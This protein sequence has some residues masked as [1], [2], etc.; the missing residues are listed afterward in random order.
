MLFLARRTVTLCLLRLLTI[1]AK[2]Q[3]VL[4]IALYEYSTTKI[5]QNTKSVL[6]EYKTQIFSER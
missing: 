6:P 2:T 5:R 1:P 3:V 4:P